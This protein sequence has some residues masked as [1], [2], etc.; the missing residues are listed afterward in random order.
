[1]S[2]TKK[3][4]NKTNKHTKNTARTEYKHI[5]SAQALKHPYIYR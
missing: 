1:M 4:T 2:K 3:Q 5:H